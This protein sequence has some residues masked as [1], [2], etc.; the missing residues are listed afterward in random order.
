MDLDDALDDPDRRATVLRA[1]GR[2]EQEPSLL[3]SE[4]SP[5]G[6]RREAGAGG[7]RVR[8]LRS[9]LVAFAARVTVADAPR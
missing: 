6:H 7:G 3:G 9:A 1:I 8:G 4:P 2:V 5:H